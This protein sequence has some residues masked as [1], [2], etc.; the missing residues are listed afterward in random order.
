ML[1]YFFLKVTEAQLKK[2]RMYMDGNTVFV[3]FLIENAYF[4]LRKPYLCSFCAKDTFS[5]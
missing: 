4:K 1:S 2:A 3:F 5:S